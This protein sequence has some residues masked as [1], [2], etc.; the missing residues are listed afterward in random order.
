MNQNKPVGI[1]G[2]GRV[3]T[4]LGRALGVNG[5]HIAGVQSLRYSDAE[6]AVEFIDQGIACA[7]LEEIAQV[8]EVFLITTTDA[9]IDNVAG[10][11]ASV[12]P[13]KEVW[14][15]H[16]SG[17]LPSS[18]LPKSQTQAPIHRASIHPLLSFADPLEAL[19]KLKGA[20]FVIEG[21]RR[22]VSLARYVVN[23]LGGLPRII[24]PDGKILY[25]IGACIASNFLVTLFKVSRELLLKAGFEEN[26]ADEAILPLM[27]GALANIRALGLY[28]ALTG[29][30]ARGEISII[31]SHLQTLDIQKTEL[32]TLYRDLGQMT[33]EI[34]E[35]LG[36]IDP[37]AVA[38]FQKMFKN[39][40]KGGQT[41]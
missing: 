36:E 3:G 2:A 5:F 26:N 7:S 28:K 40:P 6:A 37:K 8:A 33:V 10:E 20:T 39:R 34:A 35:R 27:E 19:N 41:T 23:S 4:T 29:P 32:S 15:Y 13:E 24:H 31:R 22:A 14:M 25:H 9:V 11:L 21:D 16:C 17:V 1:I 38:E 12:L 30:I 18:I